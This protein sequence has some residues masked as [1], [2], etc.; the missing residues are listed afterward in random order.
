MN[1]G[2]KKLSLLLALG[3]VLFWGGTS[4]ESSQNCGAPD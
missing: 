4:Y 1:T 3:E 2:E